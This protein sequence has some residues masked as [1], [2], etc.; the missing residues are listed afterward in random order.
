[1]GCTQFGELWDKGHKD[2]IVDACY[3]AFED[4]GIESKDIQMAWFGSRESGFTGVQLSNALKLEYVPISRIENFCA[5][6]TR[7]S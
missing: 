3:E 4:A 2:L 7:A 5:I 6:R 1:M